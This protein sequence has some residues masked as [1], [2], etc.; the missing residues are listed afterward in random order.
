MSHDLDNC[1]FGLYPGAA[2]KTSGFDV[3]SASDIGLIYGTPAPHLEAAE[4]LAHDA[5]CFLEQ[6]EGTPLHA[7]AIALV[8]EELQLEAERIQR[9]EARRAQAEPMDDSWSKQRMLDLKKRQLELELHKAKAQHEASEAPEQEIAEHAEGVPAPQTSGGVPAKTAALKLAVSDEWIAERMSRGLMTRP[10]YEHVPKEHRALFREAVPKLLERSGADRAEVKKQL[11]PARRQGR[12]LGRSGLREVV[13]GIKGEVLGTIR[14]Q[15]PPRDIQLM[16][17]GLAAESS[18]RAAQSA[19]KPKVEAPKPEPKLPSPPP[20]KVEAPKPAPKV[21]A[22]KPAPKVEAPK[23]APKVEAPVH[24]PAAAPSASSH[25]SAPSPSSSSGSYVSSAAKKSLPKWALPAAGAAAL[26]LG[27]LAYALHR[28]KDKSREKSS[29]L[30]VKLARR[31]STSTY[32][33][34]NGSYSRHSSQPE[35]DELRLAQRTWSKMSPEQ[36][37]REFGHLPFAGALSLGLLGGIGGGHVG[38][39]GGPAGSVAGAT[40]GAVG[41]GLLGRELGRSS[42]R[43]QASREEVPTQVAYRLARRQIA[44]EEGG[45]KRAADAGLAALLK[46]RQTESWRN[47][48]SYLSPKDLLG[49]AVESGKTQAGGMSRSVATYAPARARLH[50]LAAGGNTVAA[51][52][53]KRG[54]LEIEKGAG[55]QEFLTR[56]TST[57]AQRLAKM[58]ARGAA[59]LAKSRAASPVRSVSDYLTKKASLGARVVAAAQRGAQQ[60]ATG[61]ASRAAFPAVAK[62][63]PTAPNAASFLAKKS[64]YM[65]KVPGSR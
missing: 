55:L 6:F 37:K 7:K 46:G 12:E 25:V 60:A 39:L 13:S 15:L 2:T 48:A 21:E 44:E 65:L 45:H 53:L 49:K 24:M 40:L 14:S 62:A 8:G 36:R 29:E 34:R 18:R 56:L 20:A 30:A 42:Q 16:R 35:I 22:P 41:G 61:M 51:E 64:P 9:D 32:Y 26:G 27:G 17:E 19:L 63:P 38:A 10:F 28:R 3:F 52:A 54:A 4:K 57:R 59:A 58:D 1:L 47:A 11:L 5:A 23:P 33:D 50:Q 31:S 43:H